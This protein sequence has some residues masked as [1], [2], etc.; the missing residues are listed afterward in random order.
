[1]LTEFNFLCGRGQGVLVAWLRRSRKFVSQNV[2]GSEWVRSQNWPCAWPCKDWHGLHESSY[3][4]PRYTR[5]PVTRGGSRGGSLGSNEP[6]FL[7]IHSTYW[8]FVTGPAVFDTQR[9]RASP[10]CLLYHLRAIQFNAHAVK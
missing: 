6:P 2:G 3:C 5:V 7:L 10:V 4:F 1:M 8:F 9:W